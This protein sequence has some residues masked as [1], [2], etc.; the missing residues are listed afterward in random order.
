M[1]GTEVADS[2]GCN[3]PSEAG[4]GSP[5]GRTEGSTGEGEGVGLTYD[6]Q[7]NLIN[8]CGRPTTFRVTWGSP[9]VQRDSDHDMQRAEG[10]GGGRSRSGRTPRAEKQSRRKGGVHVGTS[11]VLQADVWRPPRLGRRGQHVC[12]SVT[13]MASPWAGGMPSPGGRLGQHRALGWSSETVGSPRSLTQSTAPPSGDVW[14]RH[15]PWAPIPAPQWLW[16]CHRTP[17][18]GQH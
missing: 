13:W 15:S 16:G 7:S 11:R 1:G 18:K 10:T 4:R 12:R 8:R 17:F 14:H 5:A 9:G 6:M 3:G 2:W